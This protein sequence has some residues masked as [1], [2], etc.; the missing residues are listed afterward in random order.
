MVCTCFSNLMLSYSLLSSSYKHA[1]ALRMHCIILFKS[2]YPTA[3]TAVVSAVY[4]FTLPITLYL[5]R[6]CGPY[7]KVRAVI[8]SF[9]QNVPYRLSVRAI[10]S[11]K[12]PT[13]PCYGPLEA[14][15]ETVK[16][17]RWISEPIPTGAGTDQAQT[18]PRL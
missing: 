8:S 14:L 12:T 2:A 6:N 17:D 11:F 18:Q 3:R 15:V 9:G 16:L 13:V 7:Y 1:W 4:I 5:F 10:T